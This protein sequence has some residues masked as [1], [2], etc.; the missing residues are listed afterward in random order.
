MDKYLEKLI[1]RIIESDRQINGHQDIYYK[2]ERN[3]QG[4]NREAS[5]F[6]W[7]L[8]PSKQD[9]LMTISC[10]GNM[11]EGKTEIKLATIRYEVRRQDSYSSGV[12]MA[13]IIANLMLVNTSEGLNLKGYFDVE[14]ND[15]IGFKS[16]IHKA[17][18]GIMGTPRQSADAFL[19]KVDEIIASVYKGNNK[20]ELNKFKEVISNILND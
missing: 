15:V 4:V 16:N 14:S 2:T 9:E 7:S 3:K 12:D 10:S 20:E 1:E 8:G 19:D 5:I 6:K 18:S 13:C 11:T 17:I